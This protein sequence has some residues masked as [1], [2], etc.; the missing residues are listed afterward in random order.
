MFMN[1]GF[2][3]VIDPQIKNNKNTKEKKRCKC[4]LA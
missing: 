1:S 2:T 4:W 3:D